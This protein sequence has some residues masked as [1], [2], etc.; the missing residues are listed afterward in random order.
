MVDYGELLFAWFC[1]FRESCGVGA[2]SCSFN[3]GFFSQANFGE[4]CAAWP[5]DTFENIALL[6][7]EKG[8]FHAM[9]CLCQELRVH[10]IRKVFVE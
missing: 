3:F 9:D 1:V 8:F 6:P 5:P 2:S 4:D 10:E 7:C